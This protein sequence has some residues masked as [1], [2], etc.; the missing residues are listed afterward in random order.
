M[1]TADVQLRVG[2]SDEHRISLCPSCLPYPPLSQRYSMEGRRVVVSDLEADLLK[3]LV[4]LDALHALL[5]DRRRRVGPGGRDVLDVGK[6]VVLEGCRKVRCRE[7]ECLG[8]KVVVEVREREGAKV[9]CW[10]EG[11]KEA[12]PAG[13]ATSVRLDL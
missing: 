8:L 10:E 2:Q 9:L 1:R 3:L 5:E 12:S 4:A 7:E 6:E 11:G 13:E